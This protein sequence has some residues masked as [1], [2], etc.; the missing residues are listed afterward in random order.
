MTEKKADMVLKNTFAELDQILAERRNDN[1][2]STT[3][4]TE[5]KTGDQR[6]ETAH[7]RKRAKKSHA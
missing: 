4:K 6:D 2:G 1:S 3:S 7:G 5:K